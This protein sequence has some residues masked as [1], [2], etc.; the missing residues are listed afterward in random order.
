MEYR[1]FGSTDME[2]SSMGLGGL[3]ARFEG[4]KGHPPPEEKRAIYLR[5]DELGVNL[6]DMGYGDEIHIPD[7]LKGPSS[8]RY[9]SFKAK[10]GAPSAAE[11]AGVVEGQ[12]ANLRREAIDILRIHH[13]SYTQEPGLAEAI[14]GL[15]EA[16]KVRALCLIR[17]YLADQEAYLEQGPVEQADADLVIYNYVCRWQQRGIGQA[18]RAGKGVLVMKVLGGQWLDWA[19]KTRP[20]WVGADDEELVRR[21]PLGEAMRSNLPLV[22]P[23]SVGPWHRLDPEGGRP[24]TDRALQWVLGNEGVSSALVAVASVAELEELLGAG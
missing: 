20:D 10:G 2:L 8:Q 22:H 4:V 13:R 16:G 7:E 18:Q 11:L 5:A 1:R 3:L 17:H 21:A 14:Q 23:V 15:K 6:F 12:L 24:T 9:F 19:D